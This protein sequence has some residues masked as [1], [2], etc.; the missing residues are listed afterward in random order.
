MSAEVAKAYLEAHT[1]HRVVGFTVDP[2]YATSDRFC[3]LPLVAWDRLEEAF[4][5]DRVELLGPISYRLLN[6]FRRD[7][8]FEGKARHYRFASFIHPDC[9]HYAN[10][11]GEHCFIGP[12][13]IEPGA[14]IGNNVIVWGAATSL[15]TASSATILSYPAWSA[16]PAAHGSASA[17]FLAA[18]LV[19]AIA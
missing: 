10:E 3:D 4:P 8:F 7:R 11:I 12:S 16:S 14:R 9:L 15:I 2:A 5:P 19:L 6:E 13:V 1:V 17:A 18:M